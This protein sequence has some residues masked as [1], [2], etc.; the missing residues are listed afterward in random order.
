MEMMLTNLL[1]QL[2][3]LNQKP[4]PHSLFLTDYVL[5][6]STPDPSSHREPLLPDTAIAGKPLQFQLAA[7][8]SPSLSRL[9]S[10]SGASFSPP[11]YSRPLYIDSYTLH[12]L[13]H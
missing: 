8:H 2:K 4:L 3:S 9:I 13:W 11:L 6:L 5:S 12:S 7:S 1:G 10:L